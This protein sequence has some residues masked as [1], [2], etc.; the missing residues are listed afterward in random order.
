MIYIDVL[1]KYAVF[2]G[3]AGR[4]EY[5]WFVLIN[6]VIYCIV[7]FLLKKAVGNALLGGLML[8]P[9]LYLLA[10]I[11]PSWAVS[12]RR[13]HD[14]NHSGWWVLIS[15]VPLIGQIVFFIFLVMPS[16]VGDNRFGPKSS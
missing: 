10:I 2:S 4:K 9:S 13:L 11:L 16:D 7:L 1:K 15:L 12:V 8:L 5:W 3:R 14:S 6:I